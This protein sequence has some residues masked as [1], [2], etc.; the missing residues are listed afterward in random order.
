[1]QTAVKEK[2]KIFAGLA[3]EG[4]TSGELE[5]W[6]QL[7]TVRTRA[8]GLLLLYH[9]DCDNS[10]KKFNELQKL[11]TFDVITAQKEPPTGKLDGSGEE[12]ISYKNGDGEVQRKPETGRL[13][14]SKERRSS[15]EDSQGEEAGFQMSEA[16]GGRKK[17]TCRFMPSSKAVLLQFFL[18]SK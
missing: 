10:G 7:E 9:A 2:K 5:V 17:N 8:I 14:R 16:D 6:K 15:E 18:V 13:D 11:A 4:K 1:M 12:I 3:E